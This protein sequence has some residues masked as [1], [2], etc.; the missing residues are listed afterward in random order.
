M[1]T[2]TQRQTHSSFSHLGSSSFL[3][4]EE[5][6]EHELPNGRGRLLQGYLAMWGGKKKKKHGFVG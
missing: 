4:L 1:R 2:K 5:R 6:D 3:K